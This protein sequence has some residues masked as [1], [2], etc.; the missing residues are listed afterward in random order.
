MIPLLKR[1]EITKNKELEACILS[2]QPSIQ[3]IR[4]SWGWVSISNNRRAGN[5][6]SLACTRGPDQMTL[7]SE[8]IDGSFRAPRL[9]SK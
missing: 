6:S 1:F 9:F 8:I 5:T 4:V 2:G 7:L 3:N